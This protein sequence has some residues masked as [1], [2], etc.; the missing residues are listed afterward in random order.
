[1]D[2]RD[3]VLLIGNLGFPVFVAVLVLLRIEPALHKIAE[4]EQREAE[5]LRELKE[6]FRW[7]RQLRES[8]P[9]R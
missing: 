1:M 7:L 6:E 5:M 2:V 9:Q 3:I 8:R 4:V